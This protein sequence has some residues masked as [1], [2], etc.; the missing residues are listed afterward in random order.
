[1]GVKQ[2][3]VDDMVETGSA[4]LPRYEPATAPLGGAQSNDAALQERVFDLKAP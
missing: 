4:L 1:V 2:G 3:Q